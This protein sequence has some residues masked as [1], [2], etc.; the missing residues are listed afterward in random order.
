MRNKV[1]GFV[2]VASLAL[3]AS[4]G[5]ASAF[6]LGAPRP[7]P[8][9]P[10]AC[11]TLVVAEFT[12]DPSTPYYVPTGGGTISQWQTDTFRDSSGAAGAT[13]TLAV[14]GPAMT[15]GTYTVVGADSETLP[16]PLPASGIASFTPS[17]PITVEAGDVLAIYSASPDVI[18]YFDSGDTPPADSVMQ[19]SD[20]SFPV[21]AGQT[22]TKMSDSTSTGYGWTTNLQATL[23][24]TQ[25]LAV[26]TGVSAGG[27]AGQLALLSSTVT[28]NGPATEPIT[29]TDSVP[30]GL[31]PDSAGAADGVCSTIGQTV[32]C[33]ITGLAVGQ[34]A[35]VD[36]L[37]TPSAAGSYSN[38]VSVTLPSGDT[39][40]NPGNDTA[41]ATLSVAPA[42]VVPAPVTPAPVTPAPVTPAPVVA[43]G[44]VLHCFVPKLRGISETFSKIVLE[45]LGCKVKVKHRHSRVHKGDV[46]G[47][48][49]G[50]GTYA[51]ETTVTIEVSLGRRKP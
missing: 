31:T 24:Q 6:T 33:T 32:T 25:D 3:F 29:F 45:D 7:V 17:S 43:S 38:G 39:D 21:T 26:T 19:L 18:C 10:S 44:P 16:N 35:P 1:C 51:D 9:S 28:N 11:T 47:A 30:S 13:V 46:I 8:A 15:G 5:T 22:L 27:T 49:P 14:L 37:V 42:P 36:V 50:A 23:L 41:S 48:N 12:N 40:P 34:S 20:T 2:G 4:A